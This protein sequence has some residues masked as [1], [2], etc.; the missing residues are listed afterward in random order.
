MA[1]IK[2]EIVEEFLRKL[3]HDKKFPTPIMKEL[4]RI[5]EAGEAISKETIFELTKMESDSDDKNKEDSH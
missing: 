2:R 4:K 3:E 1:G 5:W